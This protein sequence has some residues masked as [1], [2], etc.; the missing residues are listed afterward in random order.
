MQIAAAASQ[1]NGVSFASDAAV[2]DTGASADAHGAV[3]VA[4]GA[5]PELEA[6][7]QR[8]WED[9]KPDEYFFLEVY[10]S[11]VVEHLV[12]MTGAR[13]CAWAEG[14]QM[15]VL[16]HYSPGLSRVGDRRAAAAAGA[17]Q[18]IAPAAATRPRRRARVRHAAAEEVA[19]GRVRRHAAR[20]PRA[21][22]DR[23]R[24][25][26]EL[27]VPDVSVSPEPVSSSAAGGQSRARGAGSRAGATTSAGRCRST[28][29]PGTAVNRKALQRWCDERLSIARRADGA[30]DARLPL[31]RHDVHEH[32]TAAAVSVSRDA[33]PARRGLSDP[34]AASARRAAGRRRSH[35]HVPAT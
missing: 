7:A 16:P 27:L 25:V 1:L 23:S 30:I 4:V 2:E 12:T 11:A 18:P 34:R 13:L 3:L 5:G 26:R 8:L 31:R 21:A 35:L 24:P 17:H 28:A 32:G 9:E 19:A 20:R 33:R 10:G 15:A 29:R 6:E 22:A 14:R